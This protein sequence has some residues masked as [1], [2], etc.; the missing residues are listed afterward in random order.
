M[1][2]YSILCLGVYLIA[3][4]GIGIWAGKRQKENVED[5]FLAGRG[6]GVLVLLM[7]Q[8]ATIF[9]LGALA[10]TR[11]PETGAH[12]LRSQRYIKVLAEEMA[13]WPQYA[14]QLTPDIIEMLFLSAPLH[15]IGKVAIPDYVLLKPGRLDDREFEIMKSHSRQGA[16]T[17]E[18]ALVQYPDAEFLRMARDIAAYHHER[19]DGDGYPDGLAGEKIP[20]SARIFSVADV[21]DAL[22]S[23]RVYKEAFTHDVAKNIIVEGS[24]TQ[25]D[26]HVVDSFQQ[27][28]ADFV[29]V[30]AAN[31][32]KQ[33]AE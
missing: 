13:S 4:L 12:L 1:S 7:T 24:G 15:D 2:G 22:V 19:Y 5:Y 10:E 29:A 8:A 31:K 6:L 30:A 27:C 3:I 20:L 14:Q 33:A 28:E 11:D 9:S 23:K 32:E 21:Y 17:L 25:F 16:E 18:L 26:P